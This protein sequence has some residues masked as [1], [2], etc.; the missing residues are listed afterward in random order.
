MSAKRPACVLVCGIGGGDGTDEY[1]ER[2]TPMGLRERHHDVAAYALG[3]LEPADALRCEEHLARCLPCAVRLTDLAGAASALAQLAGR[4]PLVPGS[5]P[6]VPAHRTR[7]AHRLRWRSGLAAVA[8]AVAVTVPGAAL[9]V[10]DGDPGPR[11]FSATDA[12]TGAALAVALRDREWGTEVALRVAGVRGPRV[13][14]LVAVGTDGRA[15][16]VLTWT[17]TGT[18]EPV[19]EGVT[20]LR[21]GDIDRLEVWGTDGERLVALRP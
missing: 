11:R 9:L 21:G 1:A 13:C 12:V 10:P 8:A 18:D 14:R 19:V 20:A 17:V 3:V 7:R 6:P 2:G 15:L 5:V 4:A 16:P